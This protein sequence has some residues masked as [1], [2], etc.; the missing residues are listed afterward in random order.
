MATPLTSVITPRTPTYTPR[1]GPRQLL[2]CRDRETMLEGP[3]NTG[4]SYSALWKM[5]LAAL[6]YP[7][8]HGLLL[9]KTLVSLKA[10]TLV[11]FRE[12]I[13]GANSPVKFWAARADEAAHYAYPNGSKVY[14]GGMDNAAKIMSTEYDMVLWDEATDGDV[15][16]WEALQTRLRYGRMPYQ[17]AIACCNPQAPTHWLNQR[18]N[19]GHITR[20]TSTH[21]D[22][23]TVTA[24]YLAMLDALTGVRRTRLYLGQWAAAEGMIYED[25]W[26]RN[27]N[28]VDRFPIPKN[29][30]RF[31][32]VD[33]GYGPGHPFVAQWWAEDESGRLYRYREI[34]AMH[35]L[36][37]DHARDILRYS[38][39][40][41]AVDG[42]PIPHAIVCDHDAE[43]RATLERYLGRMTIPAHKAVVEGIQAVAARF[44]P[45]G[46]G[47]P[48]LFLLR[49]SLVSRDPYRV[50]AKQPTCTEEEIESY[51]WDTRKEQPVKDNDHGLDALRYL[52]AFRDVRPNALTQG[53]AL[54]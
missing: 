54:Y 35:R 52:V 11:T 12:R 30:T 17:Q 37:E 6:K 5:H 47:K 34:Y 14:V 50:D 9:R 26:N 27:E 7:G 16:E 10:S 31:L 19:A 28:L 42:D 23:P 13:L 20:I 48:R 4:K 45:A 32:A 36:V 18:A 21:A 38:Q 40:G 49:D 43:G 2:F 3:A 1:G 46:D 33:F 24:D 15:S 51:V 44:R 53:P 39:W 8:M 22:N 41:N 29:W 25:S